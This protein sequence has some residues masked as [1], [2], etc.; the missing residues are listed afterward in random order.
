MRIRKCSRS[1]T[2]AASVPVLLAFLAGT[3]AE[4]TSLFD[5]SASVSIDTENVVALD[6]MIYGT[7]Y[8]VIELFVDNEVQNVSNVGV[9]DTNSG[10]D[11]RDDAATFLYTNDK[12][13]PMAQVS[14]LLRGSTFNPNHLDSGSRP[15]AFDQQRRAAR[16]S[17]AGYG[18]AVGVR[19]PR[20]QPP[21]AGNSSRELGSA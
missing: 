11:P 18:S 4:A 2:I 17:G 12:D 10:V 21:A 6:W 8:A 1:K 15:D 13:E 20:A 16:D 9:A 19:R 14:I 7:S 5:N 3:P